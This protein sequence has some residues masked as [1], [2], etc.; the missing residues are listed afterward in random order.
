MKFFWSFAPRTPCAKLDSA[1]IINELAKF[2][3]GSK[4]RFGHTEGLIR[5]VGS[6]ERLE[7]FS[8]SHNSLNFLPC[9]L[10]NAVKVRLMERR[11]KEVKIL[12]SY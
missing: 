6:E 3:L 2:L 5:P 1:A 8:L 7:G 10:K 4:S 12:G 11:F 9:L